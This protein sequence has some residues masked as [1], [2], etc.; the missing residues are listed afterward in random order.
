MA[1]KDIIVPGLKIK[2]SAKTNF[3]ELCESI[4]AWYELNRYSFFEFSHDEKIIEGKKSV[5]LNYQGL[6]EIDDYYKFQLDTSIK[7]P[8]Y[9][10]IKGEKEKLTQGEISFT[11][12]A[13]LICDYED[14]WDKKPVMKFLRAIS[15]K[16]FTKNKRD[17]YEKEIENDAYDLYAK[18]KS[19]L[20]LEKFR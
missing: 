5:S 11:F 20:N 4:K 1:E 19:F 17:S 2:Q 3:P 16:F 10:I 18:V 15:D 14:K 7:L 6:K 12:K 13:I 8:N 9:E